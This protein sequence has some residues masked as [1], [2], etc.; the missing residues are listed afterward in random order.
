LTRES[1]HWGDFAQQL[2]SAT[3]QNVLT[4]DLP[5]NGTLSADASPASVAGLL[6]AVRQ[7]IN[8]RGI[9]LP[10]NVLAMSL[11]GM[12]ATQWAQRY[13][14]EVT[15]LVLINTS[16]RPF[17]G[18]AERLIPGS[19]LQIASLGARWGHADRA[20]AINA[21][22]SAALYAGI[23]GDKAI[24]DMSRRIGVR[25]QRICMPP[26]FVNGSFSYKRQRVIL[27]RTVSWQRY[28]RRPIGQHGQV[29]IKPLLNA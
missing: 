6:E 4:L 28:R 14:D 10:V 3:E 18:F 16:I 8:E 22:F 27:L 7:Q 12:V 13:P 2:A 19:W 25:D 17:S 29:F 1:R 24:L 21:L 5:G 20:E 9:A 23:Y 15:R 26:V 11:G